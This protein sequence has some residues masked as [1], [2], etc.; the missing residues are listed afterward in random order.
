MRHF[1]PGDGVEPPAGR[2][3]FAAVHMS[4]AG[5]VAWSRRYPP[6]RRDTFGP[7]RRGVPKGTWWSPGISDNND[8]RDSDAPFP[9]L[10][11]STTWLGGAFRLSRKVP[12]SDDVAVGAERPADTPALHGGTCNYLDIPSLY[13]PRPAPRAL[14]RRLSFLHCSPTSSE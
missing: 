14:V 7:H 2:R 9:T 5:T 10:G 3:T 8:P 1:R 11:T 12:V 4:V 13:Q 6:S